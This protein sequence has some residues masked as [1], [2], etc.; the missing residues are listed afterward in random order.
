MEVEVLNNGKVRN[1]KVMLHLTHKDEGCNLRNPHNE[2]K[3]L[4]IWLGHKT[5]GSFYN[6]VLGS[7]HLQ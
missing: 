2:C 7:K 5:T 4:K 1:D 3:E 6:N